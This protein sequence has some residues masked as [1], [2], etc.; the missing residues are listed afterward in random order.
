[1]AARPFIFVLAGVNGAGKSS[2]AGAM[3]REHG[4]DWFNPDT[5]ARELA[6]ELGLRAADA[7]ARACTHGKDRLEAAIASR[8]NYAFETTLGCASITRL[9][10]KAAATHDIAMLYCGLAS[11][12]L[13]IDR[14]QLRVAH[15][16]HAIAA[17]KIRERWDGSRLNLV[18]LMPKLARLQ[19]FDNSTSVKPGQPIPDPILVLELDRGRLVFPPADDPAALGAVPAWA[20]PLVEAAIRLRR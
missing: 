19:V 1:M 16:G 12:Q 6:R 18:K 17:E 2:V 14:V 7:N 9:L 4:L 8:S 3:L 11:P 10:E 5:Y 20:R 13:H 15:G